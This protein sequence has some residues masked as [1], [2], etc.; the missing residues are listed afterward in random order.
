MMPATVNAT[1]EGSIDQAPLALAD[2]H[3]SLQVGRTVRIERSP[4]ADDPAAPAWDRLVLGGGFVATR[5]STVYRRAHTLPDYV[6]PEMRILLVGLNPSPYA[7]DVGVGFARPGNRFWPALL[8][9]KLVDH[10]RDPRRALVDHHI[11]MTDLVK[12]ATARAAELDAAEFQLGFE[13]VRSLVVWLRPTVACFV[14]LSGWRAAADR[15]AVAGRQA[16][17][18]GSS[19]VYVMPNPS[20]LNAHATVDSLADHFREVH[21]LARAG[22]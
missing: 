15:R 20:G 19:I 7:A 12:R 8:S 10:A 5:M 21:R 14:G 13:R 17:P 22:G 11:G 3:R 9:A 18:M 1:I 4:H 6:G 16:Q 2:L